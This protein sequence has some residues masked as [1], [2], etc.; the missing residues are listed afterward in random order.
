MLTV[1]VNTGTQG[2]PV[3]VGPGVLASLPEAVDRHSPSSIFLIS[4]ANVMAAHGERV[5]ALLPNATLLEVPAGEASKSLSVLGGLYDRMLGQGLDR[6]SLVVAFG[7]G[8]VGDL[9]GFAAATALRGVPVMQ[10]PTSLLAMVDSSVGGKT[11][12]NHAAGKNLIGAFHQPVG[13]WCDTNL[14]NTLPRREYLSALAEVIKTT[15][16]GAPGLLNLISENRDALLEGDPDLLARVIAACVE[17]KAAV[18]AED[19]RET[20][21]RRAVLNLGHTLAHVIEAARPGEYLHGEAVAIG[22]AA[23][24]RL[25]VAR[26]GLDGGVEAQTLELLRAFELPTAAPRDLDASTTVRY[27]ASDKKRAGDVLRLVLLGAVGDA[28]LVDAAPDESLA[29]AMLEGGNE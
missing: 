10:V 17:F 13:V 19:E 16:L 28:R 26:C 1:Q 7:G 9:A 2:Y 29:S 11:G 12:I 14:L 3:H 20:T 22:L 27:L 21:G 4:D 15:L 18:V 8:V 23:A 25:S 24:L 6:G 5:A